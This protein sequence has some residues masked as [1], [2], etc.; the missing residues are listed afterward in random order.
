MK[1]AA[2]PAASPRL[3]LHIWAWAWGCVRSGDT[4]TSSNYGP[5]V[6]WF[7]IITE[8]FAGNHGHARHVLT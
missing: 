3:G 1:A 4:R 6:D 8:N 2:K 5:Q 7:E